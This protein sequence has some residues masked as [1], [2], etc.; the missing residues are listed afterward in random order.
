MLSFTQKFVIYGI[1]SLIIMAG[2]DQQIRQF[3]KEADQ[4]RAEYQMLVNLK[5]VYYSATE[6]KISLMTNEEYVAYKF[7]K[8]TENALKISKCESGG[9]ATAVGDGHLKYE[10]HGK[11]YGMS[12]GLFQIRYLPGRPTPEQLVNPRTNTD[13]A[14]KIFVA[15]GYKFGTTSGWYNCAKK[16]NIN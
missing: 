7:G 11:T 4:R 3:E 8:H 1:V 9:R 12:L 5:P 14:W 2:I 16:L 10:K 15:N 6:L 13:T